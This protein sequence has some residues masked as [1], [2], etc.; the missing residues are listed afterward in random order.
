MTA[1][2]I[3]YDPYDYDIDAN[4]HPI[5]K[6]MRDEAPLWFNDRFN[7]YAVSRFSDVRE[8]SVDWR[9]YSSA[10]GS[11]LELIDAGPAV[12]DQIRNMLFEDPPI[13]DTHRSILARAFTPRRI[14]ELEPQMR[15]LCAEFLDPLVGSGRFDFVR[16]YG[17]RLPMMVIGML[18]GVPVEDRP[19]LQSLADAMVHR[20]EGETGYDGSAQT[21]AFEYFAGLVTLRRKDP[22]DDLV[23]V[24]TH[25]DVDDD[26]NG[27]SRKLDDAELLQY[28]SL[29]SAAGN[30]TVANLMGWSGLTLAAN[31]DQ[32][33][34][35][36]DH[37]GLIGNAVEEML[38]Y[39]APSPIQARVVMHDV[40]L[41]GQ[42]VP[43]GSKMALLTASANRDDRVFA[44]PDTFDVERKFEQHVSLGHGI[45]FCLGASLARLEGRVG[46]EEMLKR[47]PTW[48]VDTA[49][50]EM[51][52]T[53][54]VRGWSQL[55][56]V[57]R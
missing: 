38:R 35:L 9:T 10:F 28:I 48:D 26:D 49:L 33:R 39:E 3:Y 4:P 41:Y 29:V 17:A 25:A 37:P 11:V 19:Y 42:K 55:P 56:V 53:S 27:G 5:W 24:L 40:E 13:H 15:E 31:P 54:T 1:A 51:V 20:D 8:M 21:K 30:E 46:L 36:V 7:F 2:D 14:A 44:V 52:H 45:H 32:R 12:L 50:A 34:K 47:F 57:V 6:R 16:D 43:K 23:S 18:L 22:K